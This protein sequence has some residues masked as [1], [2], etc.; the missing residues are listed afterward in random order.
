MNELSGMPS[1]GYVYVTQR[2]DP[3]EELLCALLGASKLLNQQPPSASVSVP[4]RT[5]IRER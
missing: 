1:I 2:K 3:E 4:N 5:G